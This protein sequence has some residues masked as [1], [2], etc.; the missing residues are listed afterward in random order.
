MTSSI[1]K[2]LKQ[3][4]TAI[5]GEEV[6]SAI[7][8]SIEQCYI[9]G[10]S[11][12]DAQVNTDGHL[13][14]TF[15][16]A[17]GTTTTKDY[18]SVQ[19]PKG[20]TGA[21]FDISKLVVHAQTGAAGTEVQVTQVT[22]PEGNQDVTF[23]IPKGQPGDGDVSTVDGIAPDDDKDVILDAVSYGRAQTLTNAQKLQARNN[24]GIFYHRTGTITLYPEYWEGTEA[25]YTYSAALSNVTNGDGVIGMS[26]D[27][28]AEQ[29]TAFCDAQIVAT[30]LAVST[31]T[32][33]ATLYLKAFG[34]KPT[35]QLPASLM[36]TSPAG[37]DD[38]ATTIVDAQTVPQAT[39]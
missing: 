30:S 6:R 24:V 15:L 39:E 37:A 5:Y 18:G 11:L 35:V 33:T 32:S 4:Q 23:T 31:G 34:T 16:N 38:T 22:T 7:H 36:I 20:D 19:G 25:P 12:Y 14:L 27:V 13:I 9:D 21:A 1:D 28:T 8:D 26:P 29:Y 17:D 3:I 10:R 2:F